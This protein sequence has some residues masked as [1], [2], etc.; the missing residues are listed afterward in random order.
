[1]VVRKSLRGVCR[2]VD[3]AMCR[4]GRV[5][6]LYFVESSWRVESCLFTLLRQAA[7]DRDPPDRIVCHVHTDI[8][9]CLLRHTTNGHHHR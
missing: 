9:I 2:A 1:M 4:F 8:H 5:N 6:V 7:A 3:V